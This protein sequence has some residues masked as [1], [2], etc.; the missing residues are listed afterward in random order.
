[1]SIKEL[2]NDSNIVSDAIQLG[3]KYG[4]EEKGIVTYELNGIII[5]VTKFE[6]Y[7]VTVTYNGK[8]VLDSKKSN[9][10]LKKER[11]FCNFKIGILPSLLTCANN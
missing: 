7:P 8:L 1:M 4:T 2:F 9:S 6:N 11:N 3:L 5:K 10:V